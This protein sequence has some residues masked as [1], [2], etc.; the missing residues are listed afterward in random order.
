[1]MNAEIGQDA[2]RAIDTNSRIC[3]DSPERVPTR[4]ARELINHY[5]SEVKLRSDGLASLASEIIRRERSH[6]A[7]ERADRLRET[8]MLRDRIRSLESEQRNVQ[9]QLEKSGQ[10]SAALCNR[11]QLIAE[12]VRRFGR[13]T[14]ASKKAM[15]GQVL[16]M[17]RA[18]LSA[19]PM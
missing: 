8:G 9:R 15:V 4:L 18:P 5:P 11:L 1:M 12:R 3:D 17:A 2:R 19:P 10:E 6:A 14:R 13:R 7:A 16:A